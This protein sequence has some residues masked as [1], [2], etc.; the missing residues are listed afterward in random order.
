MG[1]IPFERDWELLQI[2]AVNVPPS[3]DHRRPSELVRGHVAVLLGLFYDAEISFFSS[4]LQNIK[5][6]E[7]RLWDIPQ[8]DAR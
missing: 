5:A 6:R 4:R 8:W 2:P 7:N 1:P 3:I